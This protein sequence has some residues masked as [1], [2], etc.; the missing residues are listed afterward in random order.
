MPDELKQLVPILVGLV[1]IIVGIFA[2]MLVAWFLA[3]FWS[4][5]AILAVLVAALVWLGYHGA[6][7]ARV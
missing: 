2:L 4:H 7:R 6:R 5:P 3:W 1:P